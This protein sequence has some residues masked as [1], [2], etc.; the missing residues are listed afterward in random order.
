[1]DRRFRYIDENR[2]SELLTQP[3]RVS[4]FL[5]HK[6]SVP[7]WL[8]KMYDHTIYDRAK[9]LHIPNMVICR[10][11]RWANILE[12]L[13]TQ[14]AK[15]IWMLWKEVNH[16]CYGCCGLQRLDNR[17]NPIFVRQTSLL[18]VSLPAIK[19]FKTSSLRIVLSRDKVSRYF[20]DRGQRNA[21]RLSA[22][23]D[24]QGGFRHLQ[25]RAF[26]ARKWTPTDDVFWLHYPRWDTF[27]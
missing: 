17:S 25:P 1:M 24:D 7:Q 5:L 18:T 22:W 20:Y 3:G 16:E 14:T 6:H 15:N 4:L 10:Y 21:Y 11:R 26:Y 19:V 13:G 9:I 23:L 2:S 12:H 27:I 8:C